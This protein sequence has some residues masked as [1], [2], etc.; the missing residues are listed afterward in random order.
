[1]D[2]R[3]VNAWF[4]NKITLDTWSGAM[5][6]RP[7]RNCKQQ[8]NHHNYTQSTGDMTCEMEFLPV[9]LQDLYYM[10]GSNTDPLKKYLTYKAMTNL[11]YLEHEYQ[12]E[13][14]E[15]PTRESLR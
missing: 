7:C 3:D 11:E 4:L 10:A 1:V 14:D 8:H 2:I 5:N 12:K 6:N 15:T 13:L 9:P